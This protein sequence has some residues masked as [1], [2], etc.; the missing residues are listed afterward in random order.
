MSH[1]AKGAPV[2]GVG[3]DLRWITTVGDVILLGGHL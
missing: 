2:L 1:L 3:L